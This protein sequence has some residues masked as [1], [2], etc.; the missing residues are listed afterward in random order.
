MH[1]GWKM[2]LERAFANAQVGVL[3]QSERK[4]NATADFG[5]TT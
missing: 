3:K 5:I 4:V 2:F 1:E